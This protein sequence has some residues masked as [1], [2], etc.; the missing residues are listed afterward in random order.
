MTWCRYDSRVAAVSA[1]KF[2]TFEGSLALIVAGILSTVYLV[3]IKS[4]S[5]LLKSDERLRSS[6]PC[7]GA[8]LV[9]LA[10]HI[11]TLAVEL[12][13]AVKT[14]DSQQWGFRPS[15]IFLQCSLLFF[16]SVVGLLLIFGWCQNAPVPWVQPSAYAIAAF[17]AIHL[18]F[19]V[20]QNAAGSLP[21]AL[22]I[23][24][25]LQ[26]LAALVFATLSAGMCVL[27]F[28]QP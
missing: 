22:I 6:V 25:G 23:V 27:L 4:S 24:S 20:A 7:F 19:S 1:C 9:L 3:H 11:T 8:V 13:A 15:R 10:S 16:Y 5:K 21:G 18:A 12:G 28:L 26:C 17:Y 14:E 2:E